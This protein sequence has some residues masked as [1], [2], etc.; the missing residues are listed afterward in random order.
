MINLLI[1]KIF[2]RSFLYI[3]LF[4]RAFYTPDKRVPLFSISMARRMASGKLFTV[5]NN[6]LM[7]NKKTRIVRRKSRVYHLKRNVKSFNR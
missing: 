1:I 6:V 2:G 3:K 7:S 4:V 5:G